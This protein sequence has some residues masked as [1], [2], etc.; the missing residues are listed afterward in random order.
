[1]IHQPK[2]QRLKNTA[3][4]LMVLQVSTWTELGWAVLTS[5]GHSPQVAWWGL[6]SRNGLTHVMCSWGWLLMGHVSPAGW[7]AQVSSCGVQVSCAFQVPLVSPL[8]RSHQPGKSSPESGSLG[9]ISVT[10]FSRSGGTSLIRSLSSAY[11]RSQ[12]RTKDKWQRTGK[13][14]E[15]WKDSG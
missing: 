13:H 2:V 14:S 12:E 15:D 11:D 4:D 5:S 10:V 8:R 9:A 6:E 3:Y 1:M 7:P